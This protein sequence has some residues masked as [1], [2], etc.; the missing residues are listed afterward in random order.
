MPYTLRRPAAA[1][2]ARAPGEAIAPVIAEGRFGLAVQPVCSTLSR[3]P[4]HME[5]LLRPPASDGLSPRAFV[6]AAEAAGLGPALDRAVLHAARTLPGLVSVNVCAR[7]LQQRDFVRIVLD[8]GAGAL[9]LV[10]TETVDD[11]AA[12]AA[13]V[14]E[15]RACGVRVALDAVDG[16]AA[17]LALAQAARFDALKLSGGV[18]RAAIAGARG[19]RLLGELL[20]L[21][22]AVGAR[23]IATQIETLPQLW[24]MQREGVELVQ[25]WLLGAPVTAPPLPPAGDAGQGLG[26]APGLP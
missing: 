14:T 6:A 18:V 5:A 15:L 24:A 10:R 7:S 11:L 20:R 2:G 13:A 9:E 4:D 8:V 26:A 21:A 12:V 22:E 16:G 23:V 1:A 19:R 25:G 3:A 17:S